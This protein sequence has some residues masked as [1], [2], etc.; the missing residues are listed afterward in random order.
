M[1]ASKLGI[2]GSRKMR[3]DN[4]CHAVVDAKGQ[5]GIGVANGTLEM[6]DPITNHPIRFVTT[7]FL[8]VLFGE[9]TKPHL[10]CRGRVLIRSKLQEKLKTDEAFPRTSKII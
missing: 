4:L 9:V 6:V 1:F 8:N 2:C 10:A 7:R 5:Y 3:K